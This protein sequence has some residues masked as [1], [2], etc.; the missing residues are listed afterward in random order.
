MKFKD[1]T[2]LNTYF[3]LCSCLFG[4]V[5]LTKSINPDNYGYSGYGI[6]FDASL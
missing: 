4:P 3:T 6:G 5:K 2:D 1:S